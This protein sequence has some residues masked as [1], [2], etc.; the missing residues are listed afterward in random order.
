MNSFADVYDYC[1]AKPGTEETY[2]FNETTLVFKVGGKMYALMSDENMPVRINLKCDPERA[3]ELRERYD[4]V[5]PGYHMNK[6]HWNTV[7]LNG[8]LSQEEIA[9]LIDH[10]YDLIKASLPKKIQATL[11]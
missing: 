5:L 9:E 3:L 11:E 4:V 6:Q 2:P 1:M 8:T 10:S 7:V